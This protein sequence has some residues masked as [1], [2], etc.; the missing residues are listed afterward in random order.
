MRPMTLPHCPGLLRW[1]EQILWTGHDLK[2]ETEEGHPYSTHMLQNFWV[3]RSNLVRWKARGWCWLVGIFTWT[4]FWQCLCLGC[5]ADWIDW[6]AQLVARFDRSLQSEGH[7]PVYKGSE[8]IFSNA[9]GMLSCYQGKNNYIL[10]PTPHHLNWDA[11][12][13]F[14]D[15]KFGVQD[16][17][18]CQPQKTLAYAKELQHWA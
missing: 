8:G 3:G 14:S 1:Q 12:L 6:H 17:R 7:L 2:W 11:Y 18:I 13:P 5:V 4:L 15:M 10:P 16:Y 9:H